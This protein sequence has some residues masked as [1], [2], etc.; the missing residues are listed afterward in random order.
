MVVY[1]D[2]SFLVPIYVVQPES[3]RALAYMHRETKPLP[4]TP[5]H[6]QELRNAIR[7]CAFRKEITSEMC[8]SA[9]REVENDLADGILSHA[10]IAWTDMLQKVEELGA[11]YTET[12]GIRSLDIFHVSCALQ[13]KAKLFLTFDQRQRALAEKA[14]MNVSF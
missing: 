5:F 6:R 1:A 3:S 4:F 7:L 13:L 12:M 10:P 2:T 8:R 14:G 9:L 11:A